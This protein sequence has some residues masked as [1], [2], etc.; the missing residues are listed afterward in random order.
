MVF[1]DKG[2]SAAFLAALGFGGSAR[3]RA[4]AL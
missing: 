1:G 4:P 3:P 2:K